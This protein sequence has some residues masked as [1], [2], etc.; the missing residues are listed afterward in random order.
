MAEARSGAGGFLGNGGRVFFPGDDRL[1][2]VLEWPE[3][4]TGDDL[5]MG[6]EVSSWLAG[7]VVVAHPHPLHG[8][9]MDQPVVYRIAK[10]CRKRGFVTLR[11]NFRGVGRSAGFYSGDQEYRDVGAALSFLAG[12]LAALG[13]D[14]EP[15]A[16]CLPLG[17]AGYSFGSV[18]AARIAAGGP[19][20]VRALA[21][22]TFPVRWEEM[23]PDTAERLAAYR[24]PVLAVCAEHDDI[25]PP[26]EVEEALRGLGLDFRLSLVEGVGH[27]LEGK[28][29]EVGELVADFMAEVVGRASAK[30]RP[31]PGP[32]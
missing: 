15:S 29:L 17:L 2:G 13:G 30:A 9:T 31:T 27:F 19:V 4:M 16:A 10:C 25:A 12:Q 5:P 26:E 23:P 32:K 20:P 14:T 28:H 24:G 8:A 11:F 22:V 21:L 6:E 7:G 1:E 18:M 3:S